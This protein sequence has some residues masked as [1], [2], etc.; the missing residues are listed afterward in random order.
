MSTP[1]A[2]G[3]RRAPRWAVAVLAAAALVTVGCSVAGPGAGG[4]NS[5]APLLAA[6]PG[7]S[8]TVLQPL[9]TADPSPKT[10]R[11]SEPALLAVAGV[12]V[13]NHQG[14]DRVVVDLEGDGDPG[15]YV[16]YTSAPMV[17]TTGRALAVSGN[18]FL[19]INVDGTVPPAE[20]N[21]EGP[22]TVDRSGATGNVVE[23]VP[24]GTFDGRSQ[25]VVGLRS[26][27]PYSV[28]VLEDPKRLVIDIVQK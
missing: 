18:A 19:N 2:P 16:A 6:L 5:A 10:Q 20:L 11:P 12:R 15:W 27:A 14:F 25:I 7:A 3:S 21:L 22:V 17:G 9:G 4:Q 26:E 24:A 1:H 28:Q 23:A 13:G 8:T